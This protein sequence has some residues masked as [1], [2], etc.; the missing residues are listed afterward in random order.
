M[1]VCGAIVKG[2]ES[3]GVGALFG[4]ACEN[5]ASLPLVLKHSTK[6]KP[7]V[8]QQVASFMAG[9][10]VIYSNRLGVCFATAGHGHC[11]R[12]GPHA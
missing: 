6:I 4:G 1:R 12:G 5:V 3:L 8:V 7:V 11:S 9:G 10:C 2:L